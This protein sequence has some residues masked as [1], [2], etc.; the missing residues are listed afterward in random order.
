MPPLPP[1]QIVD[2]GSEDDE[3]YVPAEKNESDSE[4]EDGARK[5]KKARL[6]GPVQEE[7]PPPKSAEQVKAEIKEVEEGSVEARK[8]P[9]VVDKGDDQVQGS[10]S[11][12]ASSAASLAPSSSAALD[13][14]VPLEAD[15]PNN[16]TLPKKPA[17]APAPRRPTKSKQSL[18]ALAAATKPKKISTLEKSRLDWNDHLTSSSSK[19]EVDELE[20][21][22]KGGGGYLDKVDFLQRVDERK[23]DA[24]SAGKRRR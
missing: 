24:R 18:A 19:E 20:R 12:T 23:E 5:T 7:Q 4:S 16:S 8:W 14:S 22:R 9:V 3:D 2:D 6:S 13:A 1:H 10:A 11:R 17:L 21:M 15:L